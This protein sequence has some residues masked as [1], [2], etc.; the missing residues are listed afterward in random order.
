MHDTYFVRD[1]G[2]YCNVS[3]VALN[4]GCLLGI[5]L[6][7]AGLHRHKSYYTLHKIPS[8]H[9]HLLNYKQN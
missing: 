4:E 7:E 6:C 9:N 8:C 2:W 1:K 5:V 3:F